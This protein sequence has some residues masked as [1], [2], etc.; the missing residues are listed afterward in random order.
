M[1]FPVQTKDAELQCW[2]NTVL[3][4][5]TDISLKLKLQDNACKIPGMEF[6]QEAAVEVV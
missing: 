1:Y 2:P 6:V 4:T 5:R 3:A